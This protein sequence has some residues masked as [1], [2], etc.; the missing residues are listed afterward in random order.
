MSALAPRRASGFTLV[1]MLVGTT[2]VIFAI[3]LSMSAFLA[4]NKSLKG[5]DA[6]RVA[7]EAS[8]DALLQV[9]SA[10]RVAGWGIDP[11]YSVDMVYQ[12]PPSPATCRDATDR[13]DEL[14]VVARN[15]RYNW[16]SSGVGPCMDP[17]GCF[18][19]NGWKIDSV[20]LASSPRKVRVTLRPNQV[21]EKGRVVLA[22]C[23]GG[24]SPVMLTLSERYEGG[25]MG[26]AVTL[27]PLGTHAVPYNEYGLTADT[28][29]RTCHG[30]T[31]ASLF[32]VDRS[33][34]FVATYGGQP[35]LMLD[36]GLDTDNDG[37][38]PPGDADDLVPVAK[39]ADDFQV[40]YVLQPH[41]TLGAPDSNGDWVVG[42]DRNRNTPETL[43]LGAAAPL[44]DTPAD[45]AS[46][47]TL[48]P[49]NVRGVRVTLTLRAVRS[50]PEASL[51]LTPGGENRAGNLPSDGYKRFVTRSEISLRNQL[52]KNP[53][54]Y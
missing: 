33:R 9:E 30:G 51:A 5:Q 29:L 15:A 7:S 54:I 28:G 3:A 50:D 34:F 43:D 25:S 45:A 35:W 53:F 4:Y 36:P 44:Y 26:A 32:L 49:A 40:S 42:N 10:L 23:A 48:H 14:V 41:P 2:V 39:G 17:G 20:D 19:G 37:A 18:K 27:V 12:C 11:R 38:L 8:R 16:V 21:L 6:S 46:R 24:S 47:A 1:E 13:P 52:A 31:G 22:T